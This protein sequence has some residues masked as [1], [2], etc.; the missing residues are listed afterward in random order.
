MLDSMSTSERTE[1]FVQECLQ[2]QASEIKKPKPVKGE[3]NRKGSTVKQDIIDLLVDFPGL[4]AEQMAYKLKRS[5]SSVCKNYLPLLD[6]KL[7][8][9]KKLK[10]SNGGA[11]IF[12][13]VSDDEKTNR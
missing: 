3:A 5:R 7:I 12:F 4:T 11:W 6:A 1:L 13:A 10:K 2:K 8:K 9:R